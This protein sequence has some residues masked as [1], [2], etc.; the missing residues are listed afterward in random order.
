MVRVAW[1]Q[2]VFAIAELTR[3]RETHREVKIC[4]ECPT[5]WCCCTFDFAVHQRS[6]A[7][8]TSKWCT[9]CLLHVTAPADFSGST[10]KASA[11]QRVRASACSVVGAH[12]GAPSG[13]HHRA[14]EEVRPWC[15]YQ[16]ECSDL[17]KT[18]SR[19]RKMLASEQFLL[20]SVPSPPRVQCRER[21]CRCDWGHLPRLA[22]FSGACW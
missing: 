10:I 7:A 12:G 2:K 19:I 3:V 1:S 17:G 13:L 11:A 14:P 15:R 21:S 6:R 22:G 5:C 9:S 4:P 18:H 20:V 16:R 8:D